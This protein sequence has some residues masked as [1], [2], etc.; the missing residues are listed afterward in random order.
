M[1]SLPFLA[2]N[3]HSAI[4]D[5]ASDMHKYNHCTPTKRK[6]LCVTLLPRYGN[7]QTSIELYEGLKTVWWSE[8]FRQYTRKVYMSLPHRLVALRENKFS[9]V[10]Y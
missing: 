3:H 6:A 1:L 7:I 5:N 4:K 9:W 10:D 8:D 2:S